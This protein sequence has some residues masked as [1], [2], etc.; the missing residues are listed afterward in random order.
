MKNRRGSIKAGRA[1]HFLGLSLDARVYDVA[2][3]RIL[4]GV[5]V[6]KNEHREFK[7]VLDQINFW[8]QEET[9]NSA[10]Q[11]YLGRRGA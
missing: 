10:Y 8:Y 6:A 1:I 11:L 2:Y 5:Q 4:L 9:D 3:G 7:Q